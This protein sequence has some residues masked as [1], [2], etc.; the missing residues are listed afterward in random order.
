MF[1]PGKIGKEG[2]KLFC[3]VECCFCFSQVH[4]GTLATGCQS[5][6]ALQQLM[7]SGFLA[8]LAAAL[9]EFCNAE[10]LKHS[11]SLS[12]PEVFTDAAKSRQ[13]SQSE[14]VS[15]G[16]GSSSQNHVTEPAANQNA[17]SNPSITT[18]ELDKKAKDQGSFSGL[19]MIF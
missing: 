11:D 17:T 10:M 2:K 19:S 5:P 1:H 9:C 14:D 15:T 4:L 3:H 8:L 13:L 18:G 12:H 6:A 16:T 7:D